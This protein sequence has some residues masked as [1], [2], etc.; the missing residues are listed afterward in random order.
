MITKDKQQI[1][2]KFI[3]LMKVVCDSILRQK[4]PHSKG[5][6]KSKIKEG[7]KYTCPIGSK[8]FKN[9]QI[10]GFHDNGR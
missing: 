1:V 4:V 9:K 2:S 6:L 8:Q 10:F 7:G 5:K 3:E